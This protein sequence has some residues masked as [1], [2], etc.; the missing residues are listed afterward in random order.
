[1]RIGKKLAGTSAILA[2]V[3]GGMVAT[4][5]TAY[6][7]GGYNGACGSGYSVID[8]MKVGY[9]DKSAGTTYLTY[10]SS[11][12]YNCAV[13][14]NNTSSTMYIKVSLQKSTNGTWKDDAG[15][16]RSYAGPVYVYAANS[17][18]DWGGFISADKAPI[19]DLKWHDH[20]G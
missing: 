11:N 1:M 20:C 9:G 3:A 17:C 19:T 5:G 12:G 6:A 7:A 13:T 18:V 2:L 14:V 10:N 15:F 4:S 16:Y 8:S